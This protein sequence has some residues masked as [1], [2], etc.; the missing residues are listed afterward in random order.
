[1]KNNIFVLITLWLAKNFR[2]AVTSFLLSITVPTVAQGPNT[3]FA[4]W[5]SGLLTLITASY[6]GAAVDGEQLESIDPASSF[7]ELGLLDYF[8]GYARGHDEDYVH[9]IWIEPLVSCAAQSVKRMGDRTAWQDGIQYSGHVARLRSTVSQSLVLR[10]QRWATDPEGSQERIRSCAANW[11]QR[12]ISP[13]SEMRPPSN[14]TTSVVD[15][16]QGD[17][18]AT[19]FEAKLTGLK[20]SATDFSVICDGLSYYAKIS[21]ILSIPGYN[22][23]Q[24]QDYG[25]S[26]VG[27][28]GIIS[29]L[30]NV[31]HWFLDSDGLNNDVVRGLFFALG[32]R[33]Y[34]STKQNGPWQIPESLSP[35]SLPV[36]TKKTIQDFDALVVDLVEGA[37]QWIIYWSP[38]NYGGTTRYTNLLNLIWGVRHFGSRSLAYANPGTLVLHSALSD[39]GG[40]HKCLGIHYM[41]IMPPSEDSLFT[42]ITGL[43]TDPSCE[44]GSWAG[45][46]PDVYR[47]QLLKESFVIIVVGFF[48]SLGSGASSW[49]CLYFC[50][51]LL[52]LQKPLNADGKESPWRTLTMRGYIQPYGTDRWLAATTAPVAYGATVRKGPHPAIMAAGIIST[53]VARIEILRIREPLGFA[54]YRT[55][56]VWMKILA[57]ALATLQSFVYWR[58]YQTTSGAPKRWQS[59]RSILL[60]SI[61]GGVLNIICIASLL[62]LFN[63]PF[64]GSFERWI[65]EALLWLLTLPFFVLFQDGPIGEREGGRRMLYLWQWLLAAAVSL[66]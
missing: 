57:T 62:P 23:Q 35:V 29:L 52:P 6:Y 44:L 66:I 51:N 13:A 49:I 31:S 20:P 61:V 34:W 59:K 55:P 3:D 10:L 1:M 58:W 64:P 65:G 9:E 60:S 5:P 27:L 41:R 7:R 50:A 45:N 48:V 17:R 24:V 8:R 54:P 32:L 22:V 46:P 33:S 19:M 16:T 40:L 56:A 18:L 2:L 42:I 43:V 26:E 11:G 25:L 28:H 30:G 15:I 63:V 14:D 37:S 53:I 21:S 12:H 39:L 38:L 47:L 36:N 4:A